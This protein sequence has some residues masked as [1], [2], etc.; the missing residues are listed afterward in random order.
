[1]ALCDRPSRYCLVE[2]TRSGI[3]CCWGPGPVDREAKRKGLRVP[4]MPRGSMVLS[5]AEWLAERDIK[6]LSGEVVVDRSD[7]ESPASSC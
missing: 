3:K 4:W 1:M 7:D 6:K 2:S 5:D